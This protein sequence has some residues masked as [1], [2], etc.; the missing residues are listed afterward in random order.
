ML[1]LNLFLALAWVA[2]TGQLTPINFVFGFGVGYFCCCG[3]PAGRPENR[4]ISKKSGRLS[5]LR[6]FLSGNL[7][8][9]NLRVTYEI[10]TPPHTMRPGGSGRAAGGDFAGGDHAAG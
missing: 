1:L 6:A 8:L 2:F 3:W 10:L 9:A 4:A 5:A 7:V